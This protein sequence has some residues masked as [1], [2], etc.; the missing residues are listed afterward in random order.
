[1]A[2]TRIRW[3]DAVDDDDEGSPKSVL[4]PPS[5]TGPDARNVKTY[6]DYRWDSSVMPGRLAPSVDG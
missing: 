5:V 3:G 6:I 4:P 1:M 2:A